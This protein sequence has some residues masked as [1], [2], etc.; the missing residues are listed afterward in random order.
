ME[1]LRE[2]YLDSLV[3]TRR[4]LATILNII[5]RQEETMA[6][7]IQ[8]SRD[9]LING[10]QRA[11]EDSNISQNTTN[12]RRGRSLFDGNNRYSYM[13]QVQRRRT[14]RPFSYDASVN[15]NFQGT[16]T[17]QFPGLNPTARSN[18]IPSP[19]PQAAAGPQ[20][21]TMRQNNIS[22]I[23]AAALMT[24]I[25]ATLSPV[26]VRPTSLQINAATEII[27]YSEIAHNDRIEECPISR[28]PFTET[29]AVMRIRHCRH[30]FAP[31]SLRTWFNNSV[32]CPICRHDIRSTLSET[33]DNT[34]NDHNIEED[35]ENDDENGSDDENDN[36][37]DENDDNDDNDDQLPENVNSS[38]NNNTNIYTNTPYSGSFTN[39][40]TFNNADGST[41]FITSNPLGDLMN[42]LHNDVNSYNNMNT[43]YTIDF[44]PY[45][46][47]DISNNNI[48]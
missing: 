14:V 33:T 10:N 36:D 15:D 2:F 18:P 39:N 22:N 26:V 11:S 40:T 23:I 37:N 35:D 27:P 6:M 47:N 42:I 38:V 21:A 1:E 7:L 29:S 43:T 34:N 25:G 5:L 8:S 13:P 20:P 19:G 46:A 16:S 30:Y 9:E 41:S 17:T 45:F 48:N 28:E 31:E 44:T 32:R 3:S 24:E 4:T 12:R